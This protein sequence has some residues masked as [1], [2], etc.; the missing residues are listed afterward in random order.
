VP[1]SRWIAAIAITLAVTF[2]SAGIA[3][4]VNEEPVIEPALIE[5]P[6]DPAQSIGKPPEKCYRDPYP[7]GFNEAVEA[8]QK[9]RQEDTVLCNALPPAQE[10]ALRARE[11]VYCDHAAAIPEE[12]ED[13]LIIQEGE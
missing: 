12:A 2:A 1:L 8:T 13:A 6:C 3:E 7:P 10:K 11:V 9:D 4:V 5:V